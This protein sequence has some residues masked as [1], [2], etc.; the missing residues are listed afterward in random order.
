MTTVVPDTPFW[1]PSMESMGAFVTG[2]EEVAQAIQII[3]GTPL[4]SVPHRPTFGCDA[5]EQL[6]RPVQTAI[7]RI[8]QA[9]FRALRQWEPRIDV[10]RVAVTP[11][12]P[13]SVVLTVVWAPKGG[14]EVA[15]LVWL[16]NGQ[17]WSAPTVAQQGGV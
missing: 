13:G 5:Y 6:D 3:L 4:G 1:Q 16:G 8:I 2:L 14:D 12:L 9:V 7:P 15:Q 17:E 11:A 10:L